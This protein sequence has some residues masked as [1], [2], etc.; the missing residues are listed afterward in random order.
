MN[1]KCTSFVSDTV[2]GHQSI[3]IIGDEFVTNTYGR[4]FQQATRSGTKEFY[5]K[6]NFEV[7]AFMSN[8]TSNVPYVMTRIRNNF[9]TAINEQ[10]TL[11]RAV[12]VVLDDNLITEIKY[13]GFGIS[14]I[15]GTTAQWIIREMHRAVGN[16]KENLPSKAK[17]NGIPH[18]I[19][20]TPPKSV[21]FSEE[22]NLNRKKFMDCI[23]SV[24]NI[25]D[26]MTVLKLKKVWDPNN[27]QLVSD[28]RYTSKGLAAYWASI[29]NAI[30]FWDTVLSKKPTGKIPTIAV[31]QPHRNNFGHFGPNFRRGGPTRRPNLDF[32]SRNRGRGSDRFHFYN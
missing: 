32:R 12:V 4:Y 31:V 7:R 16:H 13:S 27:R 1:Q 8:F 29:D 15:L 14:L 5:I 17:K 19:W 18:F 22:E 3:W 30:E 10:V 20:V 26:D 24:S 2:R 6:E 25:Y 21:C 9:I 11:P 23:T 28:G